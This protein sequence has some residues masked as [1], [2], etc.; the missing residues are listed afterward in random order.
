M[1]RDFWNRHVRRTQASA[2]E[3]EVLREQMSPSERRFDEESI[4][5]I[6]S[7]DLVGNLGELPPDQQSDEYEP[8]P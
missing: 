5:D 8:L 6:K 2:V 7:D 3:H 1:L 4:D